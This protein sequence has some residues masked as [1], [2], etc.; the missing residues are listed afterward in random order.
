MPKAIPYQ[1]TRERRLTTEEFADQIGMKPESIR[2]R[3]CRQGHFYGLRP[4]KLPNRRLL[5]PSDSTERLTE[6]R[7]SQPS[8]A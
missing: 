3:L 4:I 8:A 6:Q 5:W 1:S 2:A 7:T